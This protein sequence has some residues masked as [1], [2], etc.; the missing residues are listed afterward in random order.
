MSNSNDDITL[1]DFKAALDEH[2]ESFAWHTIARYPELISSLPTEDLRHFA[3]KAAMFAVVFCL[4]AGR[5]HPVT[6]DI[7]QHLVLEIVP[8]CG[9][10]E[11]LY[12]GD[13]GAYGVRRNNG[14]H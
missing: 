11:L 8:R 10:L 6:E 12:D 5:R 14:M 3:G 2:D 13:N 9:D 7:L 1:Q 4:E